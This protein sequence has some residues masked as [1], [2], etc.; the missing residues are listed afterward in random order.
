MTLV[1][2]ATGESPLIAVAVIA[3]AAQQRTH[4]QTLRV[5]GSSSRARS[6]LECASPLALYALQNVGATRRTCAAQW[7]PSL[8]TR[9]INC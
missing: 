6:V 2:A 9:R 7:I 3:K 5:D 1:S 8:D 4:S